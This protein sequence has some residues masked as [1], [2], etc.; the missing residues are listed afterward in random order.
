MDTKFDRIIPGPDGGRYVG[1]LTAIDI[2]DF[3]TEAYRRTA[4]RTTAGELEEDRE[5]GAG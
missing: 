4:E 1:T 5:G 3:V 2:E